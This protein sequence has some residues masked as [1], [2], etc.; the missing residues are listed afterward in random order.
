MHKPIGLNIVRLNK[1]FII[2]QNYPSSTVNWNS[3]IH[4]LYSVCGRSTNDKMIQVVVEKN[5]LKNP[6]K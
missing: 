2:F 1:K 4:E 5:T 6:D 3:T